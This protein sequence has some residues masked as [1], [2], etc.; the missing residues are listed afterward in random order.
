MPNHR[1]A[2]FHGRCQITG[3]RISRE[4]PNRR[5]EHFKSC[6]SLQIFLHCFI[7][8]VLG[9]KFFGFETFFCKPF[10][11]RTFFF[12]VN[13]GDTQANKHTNKLI[14]PYRENYVHQILIFFVRNSFESTIED[15]PVRIQMDRPGPV[16]LQYIGGWSRSYA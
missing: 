2:P 5:S 11:F 9:L 7:V 8:L 13:C 1:V 4:M 6:Q 3:S 14:A 16:Q 10:F 12:R 15:R